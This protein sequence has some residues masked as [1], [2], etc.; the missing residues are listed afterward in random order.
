MSPS[1][2]YLRVCRAPLRVYVCFVTHTR[3]VTTCGVSESAEYERA[4]H[5]Y[6]LPMRRG[7]TLHESPDAAAL[8]AIAGSSLPP[9]QEPKG[10]GDTGRPTSLSFSNDIFTND[11][12]L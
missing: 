3:Y 9:V 4:S 12:D 7:P 11:S 8:A 10:T 6:N 5:E 2:L 1:P